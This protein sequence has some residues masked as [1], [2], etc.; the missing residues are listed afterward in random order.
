MPARL[1]AS[2]TT[3]HSTFGI[4]GL[5]GKVGGRAYGQRADHRV[6]NGSSVGNWGIPEWKVLPISILVKMQ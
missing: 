3:S 2:F 4:R 6:A 1:A 5:K